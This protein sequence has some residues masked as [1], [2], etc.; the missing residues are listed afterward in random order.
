MSETGWALD[1]MTSFVH[2]EDHE[3]S[4]CACPCFGPLGR[5]AD[6]VGDLE[7]LLRRVL[8][9]AVSLPVGLRERITTELEARDDG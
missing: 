5:A 9:E 8:T 2:A 6:R 7:R 4:R 1:P 3:D